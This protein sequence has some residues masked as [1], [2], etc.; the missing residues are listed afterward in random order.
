MLAE[1]KGTRFLS[2]LSHDATDWDLVP[3]ESSFISEQTKEA[4]PFL[5]NDFFAYCIEDAL[6]GIVQ[7]QFLQNMTAMSFDSVGANVESCCYFL[8]R[9]RFG[10][11]L[12]N[13]SLTAREQ[14]NLCS[15]LLGY[16]N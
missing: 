12:Q 14:V 2:A 5:A 6:G 3:F 15:E 4:N 13:L 7:V 8:V 16:S 11:E 1:E 10:Q 9:L